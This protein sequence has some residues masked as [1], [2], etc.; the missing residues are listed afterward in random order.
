ML[1]EEQMSIIDKKAVEEGLDFAK[2]SNNVILQL[3]VLLE[4]SESISMVKKMILEKDVWMCGISDKMITM[5]N[6]VY[7]GSNGLKINWTDEESRQLMDNMRVNLELIRDNFSEKSHFMAFANGYVFLLVDMI[8]FVKAGHF[9]EKGLFKETIE[10]LNEVSGRVIGVGK[11]KEGLVQEEARILVATLL[12]LQTYIECY[13]VEKYLDDIGFLIDRILLKKKRKL[14]DMIYVLKELMTKYS[15]KLT[16]HFGDRLI[17]LLESYCDY[18]YEDLELD[19]PK[20][21]RCLHLIAKK[22]NGK[23]GSERAVAYWIEDEKVNRYVT[24]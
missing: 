4:N 9:E 17:L 7:L 3:A 21:N 13:G 18:D 15:D 14:Q 11:L 19:V 1:S 6:P 20:T 10:L 23:Y 16:E 5:P 2:Q 24:D 22:M 12:L 8:R